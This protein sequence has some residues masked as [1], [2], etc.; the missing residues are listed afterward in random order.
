MGEVITRGRRG[1]QAGRTIGLELAE[2]ILQRTG[3][4][5][6]VEDAARELC[7]AVRERLEVTGAYLIAPFSAGRLSAV[8]DGAPIPISADSGMLDW[9]GQQPP[10]LHRL[11]LGDSEDERA[12]AMAA[13]LAGLDADVA[14]LLREGHALVGLLVFPRPALEPDDLEPFCHLLRAAATTVILTAHLR[15]NSSGL[16][17]LTRSMGLATAVQQSLLP[18]TELVQRPGFQLRGI[19]APAAECGG[20]YWTWRELTPN[21]CLIVVADA[22]GHGAA[23]ALLS[24]VAKGAVDACWQLMGPELGPGELLGVLNKAVYRACKTRYL[25]S[26]FAAVLDAERGELRYANAA[27]SFPFLIGAPSGAGCP[28]ALKL[29]VEPGAALGVQPLATYPAHVHP[30]A[31][32]DKLF[33]YTDGL[34]DAVGPT[35]ARFGER[36]LRSTLLELA[37][38]HA[39]VL[40]DLVMAR[41]ERYTAGEE[42]LDDVTVVAVEL[43]TATTNEGSPPVR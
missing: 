16:D 27:Q 18:E 43:G 1:R 32:G 21:R 41:L 6:R 7:L 35:A 8:G 3:S 17:M 39:T 22:T 24:A 13:L 26:G 25:M 34:V 11:E 30:M 14:L 19:F 28:P 20:D 9:L 40:P 12:R 29:L 38:E 10:I 31:P 4:V 42:P 33:M 2:A 5:A 23:P 37:A 36:R 15:A